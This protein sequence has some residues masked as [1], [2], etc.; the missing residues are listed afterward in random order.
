MRKSSGCH[1]CHIPDSSIGTCLGLRGHVD[2]YNL[3]K[4]S[5]KVLGLYGTEEWYLFLYFR[6]VQL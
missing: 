3:L 4:R 5:S 1:C 6:N 2:M